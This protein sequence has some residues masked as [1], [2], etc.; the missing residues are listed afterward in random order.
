MTESV[1]PNRPYR[2]AQW[3]TGTIGTCA[4]R[5]IIEHPKLALAGVL[6]H[7]QD[8]V[9]RDAGDLCG[10]TPTGVTS[11]GNIDDI[12]EL[13]ADCVLYMPSTC[14]IDEVCRLLAAGINIVTTCGG[15][16]H[17]AAM[18]PSVREPVEKACEAGGAS[19]HGTGS[20][21]GFITEAVPLVV[22]SIQRRLDNLTIDEYADLSQRNS[23]ELLFDLM[24]FG[25]S[26][27]PFE[28][29][30]AAYLRSSFGPSLQLVAH[31]IGLPLDSIEAG[32]E[33][34]STPRAA[35]IAAGG[36]AAGSVAAQ[37]ITISGMRDGKPLLRFRATW[38]CTTELEPDWD[39]HPTGWHLCVEGDAPLDIDI[40]MPVP[41]DRMAAVSPGYTANRAVNAVP[42]ICAASPG[43]QSTL[44]LPQIVAALG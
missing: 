35:D 12:I 3:A 38:Y 7:S 14:D 16:H 32:G 31:A 22:T 24:G 10:L 21:P 4:L 37:R 40:R 33:L 41:L 2:V 5:A 28:E 1:Q 25:R 18:D 19:I 34:A 23:P 30:R 42:Y 27:G 36:L 26:V 8:K 44:D 9:G 11:T 13:H 29:Y 15:F 20:S 6:V 39:V 17:P 43:I